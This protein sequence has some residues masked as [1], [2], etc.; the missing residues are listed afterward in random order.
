MKETRLKG[1]YEQKGWFWT[2]NL[3]PKVSVYGEKLFRQGEIE[4]RQWD[5]KRSKLGAALK[6]GV[7][8]IGIKPGS[9]VLYLGCSTGTTVSHVSDMVGESGRVYAL[10]VAPRV[11]RE[12]ALL[13]RRRTNIVPICASASNPLAYTQFLESVDVVFMDIAQPNQVDIFLRNCEAFLKPTGFGLLALKSRSIDITKKPK[14][15]F[16]ESKILI[17]KQMK[18]VDQRTLDPFELDHAFYVCKK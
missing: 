9:T 6:K 14:Q 16:T 2:K 15:V 17:E 1:I 10:D 3:V 5:P 11:M 8:Q 18:I 12:M 4:Y 7:S 13:T